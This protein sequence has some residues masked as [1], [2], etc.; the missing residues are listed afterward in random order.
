MTLE[1]DT[2]QARKRFDERL[3]LL[4][5][6]RKIFADGIPNKNGSK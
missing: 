2:A 1:I 4:E 6:I 3:A 5:K